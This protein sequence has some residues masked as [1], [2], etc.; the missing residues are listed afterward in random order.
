[1]IA[2]EHVIDAD[3]EQANNYARGI[4]LASLMAIVGI[5]LVV[6]AVGMAVFG[7][8]P[9]AL[10]LLIPAGLI[11]LVGLTLLGKGKLGLWIMYLWL[12]QETWSFVF[13]VGHAFASR[14]RD[15]VY[16]MV[17]GAIW[18]AFWACIV[19]YFHHRRKEFKTWLGE[20][21]NTNSSSTGRQ[22]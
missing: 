4:L 9:K 18:L 15:A 14:S 1:M 8:E 10:S 7:Q 16:T 13:A 5:F 12:A 2:N 3:S 20:F 19:A 17:L 6:A 11:V 21:K 22:D